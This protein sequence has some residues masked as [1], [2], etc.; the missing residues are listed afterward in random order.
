MLAFPV[1]LF[2]Q[3]LAQNVK[4]KLLVRDM[5]LVG[6]LVQLKEDPRREI[7]GGRVKKDPLVLSIE[8]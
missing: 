5:V 4:L 6:P 1:A 3:K 7:V 2:R 8:Y